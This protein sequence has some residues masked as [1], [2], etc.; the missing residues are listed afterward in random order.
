[1]MNTIST[2]ECD[3]CS[4]KESEE[5]C[6]SNDNGQKISSGFS[7]CC[8]NKIAAEPL[9]DRFV[10]SKDEIKNIQVSITSEYT[11]LVPEPVESPNKIEIFGS[12]PQRTEQPLYILISSLLI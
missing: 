4:V 6:C 11:S 7:E 10:S 1:M 3:M 12:P 5:N 9:K 8:Q 2:D